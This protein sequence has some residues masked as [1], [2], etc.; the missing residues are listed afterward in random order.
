[1]KSRETKLFLL[2]FPRYRWIVLFREALVRREVKTFKVY[3]SLEISETLSF[4]FQISSVLSKEG[5]TKLCVSPHNKQPFHQ[6]DYDN[7]NECFLGHKAFLRAILQCIDADWSLFYDYWI[8]FWLLSSWK[9]L[10]WGGGSLTVPAFRWLLHSSSR[11]QVLPRFELGS[12]DSKS[13]VLT[14]TP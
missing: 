8:V 9:C 14:I 11:C 13:R 6:A 2:H 1:M 10:P 4:L 7:A 12:L 5:L 3:L